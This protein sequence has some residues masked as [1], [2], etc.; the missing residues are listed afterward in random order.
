MKKILIFSIAFSI[1]S[2]NIQAQLHGTYTIGKSGSADYI[3]FNQAI[4]A[5][6]NWGIIGSVIFN[7]EAG[8]YNEQVLIPPIWGATMINTVTF[9]SASGNNDDVI[10]TYKPTEDSL[11]YTIKL[12]Y[13]QYL[14]IKNLTFS[15]D[16][17]AG[18]LMEIAYGSNYNQILNNRFIAPD[19]SSAK[20][21]F[22]TANTGFNSENNRFMNNYFEGGS[23]GISFCGLNL[24]HANGNN[25]SENKFTGQR[26]NAIFLKYQHAPEINK[27]IIHS[28]IKNHNYTG[29]LLEYC[30]NNFK[31]T[32]NI[33]SIKDG[34][35]LNFG[36]KFYKT[37]G[38]VGLEG[39]VANNFIHL[40][41]SSSGFGINET[42]SEY[43]NFYYNTIHLT[44]NAQNTVCV[45]FTVGNDI[46]FKNNN[47]VNKTLSPALTNNVL[48][49][50]VI[51]HNNLFSN[52]NTIALWHNTAATTISEWQTI[53]SQGYASVS[54]NPQF[55]SDSNLHIYNPVMN[56]FGTPISG[57]KEDIDGE[58]R[59]KTNTDIGADEF[60][61]IT[62]NLGKDTSICANTSIELDAGK[63]FKSYLWSNDST[64]QS[65][66]TFAKKNIRD[67][68][69]FHVTAIKNECPIRDTIKIIFKKYP[70]LNLGNDTTLCE[71]N[72]IDLKVDSVYA[73]YLWSTN[74]KENNITVDT[75]GIGLGTFTYWV[76][77]TAKNGCSNSDTI[78]ITFDDC[79][80]IEQ[81]GSVTFKLYPNPN[82][83][84][85]RIQSNNLKGSDNFS[86]SI[87]TLEGKE[88]FNEQNLNISKHSFD[89]RNIEKGVYLFKARNRELVVKKLFIV[90]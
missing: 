75:N 6:Q 53:S 11:N 27:N 71:K 30:S 70:D 18:N 37:K 76:D 20:L 38:F 58:K 23:S 19:S 88:V 59:D 24:M 25:F 85:F 4:N 13:T 49:N 82:N 34:G 84:K 33:I 77:V 57:I 22:S 67:T 69:D 21:L 80:S 8:T 89:L 26:S 9:Q 16:T 55:C 73:S 50:I 17:I 36:I 47:L 5:L 29:I 10:L 46:V 90:R 63:G 74:S 48:N 72:Q 51:E 62:I 7:I 45:S 41:S 44:G 2:I 40:N 35:D 32:K 61:P 83:G 54:I 65:I 68:I 3:S 31:L 1:I 66:L 81:Q 14:I 12:K 60:D 28:P 52:G 86:I 15:S 39:L 87:F 78:T 79:E 56:N 42:A 43:L 64:T